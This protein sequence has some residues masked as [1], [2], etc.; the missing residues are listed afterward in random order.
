MKWRITE[1]QDTYRM[2]GTYY[3]FF[4]EY[5]IQLWP[6]WRRV[7]NRKNFRSAVSRHV[8]FQSKL[9]AE[10]WIEDQRPVQV[11]TRYVIHPL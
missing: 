2:F 11:T 8:C 5:R 3:W 9:H 7:R 4:P 1:E 10:Q 6:F